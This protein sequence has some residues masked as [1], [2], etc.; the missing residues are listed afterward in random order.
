MIS[1]Q[2]YSQASDVWAYG[3]ACWETFASAERSGD[4][5]GSGQIT[6][7]AGIEDDQVGYNNDNNDGD[8]PHALLSPLPSPQSYTHRCEG[9]GGD[10]GRLD[11]RLLV[12][13]LVFDLNNRK[14]LV[15][16]LHVTN[17]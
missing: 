4:G 3:V 10:W 7:Y 15:S 2:H 6:P 9:R 1:D 17:A 13:G 8:Q 16:S 12:R 5:Y 11:V 14:S